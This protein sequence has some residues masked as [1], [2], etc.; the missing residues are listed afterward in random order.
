MT[1]KPETKSDE[2]N[3]LVREVLTDIVNDVTPEAVL[4]R[5]TDIAKIV[6]TPQP[7]TTTQADNINEM[8]PEVQM[9][10]LQGAGYPIDELRARILI[11]KLPREHARD[12]LIGTDDPEGNSTL[13]N[14]LIEMVH[15]AK[16]VEATEINQGGIEDQITWLLRDGYTTRQDIEE[17]IKACR[18]RDASGPAL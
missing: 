9:S 1:R 13:R 5:H 3:D 15:A 7:R 17:T 10:W 4:A 6:T 18:E 12:L 14:A 16:D 8:G 11:N 2:Y